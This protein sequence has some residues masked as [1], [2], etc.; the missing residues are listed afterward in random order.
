MSHRKMRFFEINRIIYRRDPITD[1]PTSVH[2]WGRF[3]EKGTH[4]YYNLFYSDAKITT[5]KSLKWHL[6]VLWYLN[7]NMSDKQFKKLSEH[8]I[9]PVNNFIT[10][11]INDD[12]INQVLSDVTKMDLDRPPK[13]KLRKIIF[14]DLTGLTKHD[15]LKIVGQMIGRKKLSKE[16]IY[17]AMLTINSMD[18]KIT[19]KNLA[20]YFSCSTRTI[21][22]NIDSQLRKEIKSLNEEVQCTK[23]YTI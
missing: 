22:R 15:K 14:N 1:I 10:F 12:K 21:H 11:T 23:L 7:P 19:I 9:N 4:Q 3:Y 6:Y 5:V 17:E 16:K 13:N 18:N 8:I 2:S 20:S